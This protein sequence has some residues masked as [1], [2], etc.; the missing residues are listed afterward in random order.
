VIGAVAFIAILATILLQASTTRWWAGKLGLLEP[1]AKTK[2][3]AL[4]R[5]P[6]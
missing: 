6:P 3:A 5:G 4:V 1:D 2:R